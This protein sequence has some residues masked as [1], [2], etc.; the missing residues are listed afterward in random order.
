M[1]VLTAAAD[2]GRLFV[3]IVLCLCVS[4]AAVFCGPFLNTH[5]HPQTTPP[6]LA[7]HLN[8]EVVAGT[9]TC[10][11]DA[12]DY[13]TWTY[14]YRCPQRNTFMFGVCYV[15]LIFVC[16]PVA[17]RALCFV[18]PCRCL[19]CHCLTLTYVATTCVC[20]TAVSYHHPLLSETHALQAPAAEPCL[21]RP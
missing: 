12:L 6:Q 5:T 3:G 17:A 16:G 4:S 1:C 13:L 2:A 8:A 15:S 10:R 18:S 11:Q 19:S 7:D 20:P 9:I 21:L 14:F